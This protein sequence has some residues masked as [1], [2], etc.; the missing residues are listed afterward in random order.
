MSY[1]TL[2]VNSASVWRFTEGIPPDIY[3]NPTKTWAGVLLPDD[4]RDIPCRI[5]P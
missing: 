1:A 5:M 3:G 4:L 2:L